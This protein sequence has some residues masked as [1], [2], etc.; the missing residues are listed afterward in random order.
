M[1]R[2]TCVPAAVATAAAFLVCCVCV[3]AGPAWADDDEDTRAILFSGRDIWRN[4]VFSHG[5]LLFAPGGIDNDGLLLKLMISGGVYRYGSGCECGNVVGVEVAAQVLPGWRI[6]RGDLEAKFFFG[7][8]FQEHRLWPNDPSNILN[9]RT[10]GLRMA[11]DL[12]YQPTPSTMIAF[13]GSISSIATSHS[14]RAAVGWLMFDDQLYVGP[15]IAFFASDGYRHFRLGGHF[16]AMKTGNN[17]E[18]LAAGGWARD[19]DQRSSPYV[20]LGLMK[21]L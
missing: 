12:W 9:G 20:R 11:V 14:A 18:W 19:S 4:G 3:F 5:G 16:T 6:K 17:V 7:L 1:R 2:G 15:E 13:D 10:L 21:R 8:E